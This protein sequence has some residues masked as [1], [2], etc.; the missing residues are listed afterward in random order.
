MTAERTVIRKLSLLV[1]A[2]LALAACRTTR[3]VEDPTRELREK[4]APAL[5]LSFKGDLTQGQDKN[6]LGIRSDQLL[7]S[8]RSDSRTYFVQDERF[9]L[10]RE[11][12][13]FEGG[14]DELLER[15]RSIAQRLGVPAGEIEEASVLQ[16]MNNVATID[17]T[18]S[19]RTEEPQRG[20]RYAR[21]TRSVDGVPVFSSSVMLA[22]NREGGIGFLELHW[23]EITP[24]AIAEAR[25]MREQVERGWKPPELEGAHVESVEVGIL[26]SPAVAF[27]MDVQ[28]VIRVIYSPSDRTVGKKPVLYLDSRGH[29]VPRPRQFERLDVPAE[30][31]RKAGDQP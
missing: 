27:V 9:G 5:G 16:V 6:F 26:H 13:V 19:V 29:E 20:E 11:G 2:V 25:S 1:V 15:C 22:L 24:Q 3:S 28:P 18:G 31:A 21:L 12:G 8:R 7:L 23:P 30:G 4:I 14:D 17:G 10:L